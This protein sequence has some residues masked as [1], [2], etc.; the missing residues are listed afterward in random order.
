MVKKVV[1][2]A[3]AAGGL[4]LAG[5]GMAVADGRQAAAAKFGSE[6][7]FGNAGHNPRCVVSSH[8]G[9]QPQQHEH[10]EHGEHGEHREHG[11][12]VRHELPQ[13]PR[14]HE[15]HHPYHHPYVPHFPA[16]HHRPHLPEHQGY[17]PVPL[18]PRSKDHHVPGEL[19][20]TGSSEELRLMLVG[21]TGLILGG[22]IL[23]RR[24]RRR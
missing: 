6:S 17:P 15:H 3:A 8:I 18:P 5:A 19:A 10:R 9:H 21:S 13:Q 23:F 2:V 16:E 24:T 12:H 14:H 7:I 1:A 22:A 4:V 11:E 20:K